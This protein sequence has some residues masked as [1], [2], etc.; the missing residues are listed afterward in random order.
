MLREL[1]RAE[2][3]GFQVD[4]RRNEDKYH[5]SEYDG[6]DDPDCATIDHNTM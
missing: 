6:R 5:D 2:G 3:G 4:E 1:L